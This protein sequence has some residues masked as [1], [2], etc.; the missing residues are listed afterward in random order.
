MCEITGLRLVE[1][2]DRS[3]HMHNAVQVLHRH[4][5]QLSNILGGNTATER[6]A[7]KHMELAQPLQTCDELVL[8]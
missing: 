4:A 1:E 5:G 2:I 3:R 8:N 6:D 7:S